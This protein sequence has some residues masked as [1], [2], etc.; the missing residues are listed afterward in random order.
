MKKSELR[1]IINKLIQEQFGDFPPDPLGTSDC[2]GLN[3]V[4]YIVSNYDGYYINNPNTLNDWCG[5]CNAADK[6]HGF[7]WHASTGEIETHCRCCPQF[8][9]T[10]YGFTTDPYKPPNDRPDVS[11]VKPDGPDVSW[12]EDDPRGERPDTPIGL[13]GDDDDSYYSSDSAWY[14]PAGGQIVP[15][16][17]KDPAPEEGDC[18][19]TQIDWIISNGYDV[20]WDSAEECMSNS[21]CSG[22]TTSFG[23]FDYEWNDGTGDVLNCNNLT[24][25]D[26]P[27][28]NYM[29][30]MYDTESSFCLKCQIDAYNF[31]NPLDTQQ[32]PAGEPF[33]PVQVSM[34]E[35]FNVFN[36]SWLAWCHCCDE[37]PFMQIEG[38]DSYQPMEESIKIRLQE[39]ANI[40]KQ[41]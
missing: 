10:D 21:V 35:M 39:L 26:G 41:K 28:V 19:Y 12:I 9:E 7:Y 23:W 40:R 31:L 29:D 33:D 37:W 17:E 16:T 11:F 8:L 18:V 32:D 24:S 1:K 34:D 30:G 22:P 3:L 25:S 4:S 2:E 6:V 20:F 14:C 36:G 38:D 27:T 5:R 13:G 15:I